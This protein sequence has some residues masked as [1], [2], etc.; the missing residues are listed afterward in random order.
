MRL[1]RAYFGSGIDWGIVASPAW[2]SGRFA[3]PKGQTRHDARFR[4]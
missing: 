1:A 4:P 3:I 2:I